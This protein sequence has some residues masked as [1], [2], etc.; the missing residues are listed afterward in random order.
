MLG[1]T[2]NPFTVTHCHNTFTNCIKNVIIKLKNT[3]S[4]KCMKKMCNSE[5]RFKDVKWLGIGI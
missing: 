5:K 2:R 3:Y 1:C 4:H